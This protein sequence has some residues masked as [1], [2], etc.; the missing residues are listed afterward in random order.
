MAIGL[1]GRL[2]VFAAV[3]FATSTCILRVSITTSCTVTTGSIRCRCGVKFA[4]LAS[5]ITFTHLSCTNLA[6]RL[7]DS[8]DL[9]N[10]V[11]WSCLHSKIC[12]ASI[13]PTAIFTHAG[14]TSKGAK[15]GWYPCFTRSCTRSVPC[16]KC[17]SRAK[18]I[19]STH[20]NGAHLGRCLWDSN[21][22]WN[23]VLQ[24][25]LHSKTWLAFAGTQLGSCL[26]D[27]NDLWNFALRSYLHS[28]TWLASIFP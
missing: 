8:N 6:R 26:W 19:I 21:D 25:C 4:G 3:S 1:R 13:F 24:S 7:W 11:L 17:A 14:C 28:K 12:L 5:R 2:G 10:V 15:K 23:F 20:F 9:W 27:S 16:G 22:L 18:R